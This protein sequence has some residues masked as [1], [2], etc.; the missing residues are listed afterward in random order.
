MGNHRQ[1][2]WL[3]K[4]QKTKNWQRLALKSE[5][6]LLMVSSTCVYFTKKNWVFCQSVWLDCLEI[7]PWKGL[8][9]VHFHYY[10]NCPSNLE[11]DCNWQYSRW[12]SR[13]R[14]VRMWRKKSFVQLVL[15]F[16]PY[17]DE[18]PPLQA[19]DLTLPRLAERVGGD[20][21]LCVTA[22]CRVDILT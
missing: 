22:C 18:S 20:N 21:W 14:N 7:Y 16:F 19:Q 3:C 4:P 1:T 9:G 11:A 12:L 15:A 10:L 6:L 8:N 13:P 5:K 2:P 17:R